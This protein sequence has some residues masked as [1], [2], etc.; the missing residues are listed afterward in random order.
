MSRIKSRPEDDAS[1]GSQ[2]YTFDMT[3][4]VM[5]RQRVRDYTPLIGE[6]NQAALDRLR[7]VVYSMALQGADEKLVAQY[8]GFE[9]HQVKSQLGPVIEMAQ[10]ELALKI[11]GSNIEAALAAKADPK[12]R[13]WA[14]KQHAG[15]SDT[16]SASEALVAG[17]TL[18]IKVVSNDTPEMAEV[19]ADLDALVAAAEHKSAT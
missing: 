3:P 11:R 7:D 8:F 9:R 12:M 2:P 5:W 17:S 6:E 1:E 18:T 16:V 19:R 13:V 4:N 10:A 14:A 15:Q